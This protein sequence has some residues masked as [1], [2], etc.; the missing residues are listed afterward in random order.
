MTDRIDYDEKKNLDD[1]AISDVTLFR[2]EWMAS[3]SVWI[4]CYREGK[5]DVVFWLNS[6]RKITGQHD[7]E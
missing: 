5:P 6:S 7:Y 4:K 2:M 1:V 3:G